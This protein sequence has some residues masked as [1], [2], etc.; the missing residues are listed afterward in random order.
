VPLSGPLDRILALIAMLRTRADAVRDGVYIAVCLLFMAAIP[1]SAIRPIVYE[2]VAPPVP[3][4]IRDRDAALDVDVRTSEGERLPFARVRALAVID[5]RVHAAGEGTTDGEGFVHIEHL[6]RAEHWV[7]ADA[8]GRARGATSVALTQGTRSVVLSLEAEHFLDLDVKDERGG[9]LAGV[10]IEVTGRDPL[11]VGARTDLDGRARVG[12]LT[13]GPYVATARLPGLEEVTQRGLLEGSTAHFVLRRLGVIIARVRDGGQPVPGA[14]VQ[15]SGAT[16]WPPRAADT[17]ATGQLRIASLAAGTYALRANR[18][19]RVSAIE[20]DVTVNGGDERE[21]ELN[22]EP[23]MHVATRVIEGDQEG[24]SD[25]IPIAG[26]RV[27]LVEGGLS[28]FPIE[29]VTD[30]DGQ[31]RL[32]PISRGSAALSARA[33]GYVARGGIPVPEAPSG[34]VVVA[35]PRA[36]TVLGRVVDTRGFPVDG[37]TIVLF[38]TDFQGAPID[39]DPRRTS[40]R[41]AHFSATLAG[42]RPLV[43]AGELGVMPGPVPPIPRATDPVPGVASLAG[44]DPSAKP[45]EPWVTRADGTYRATPATPGRIRALVRHPQYVEVTSDVVTLP[46]GGEA[47]IDV[48]MHAGG[49]LEGHV[50]DARGHAIDGARVTVSAVRGGLERV[51]RTMADGSFAFASLPEAIG[52]TV[53]RDDNPGSPSVSL[54]LTIPDG[55]KR[56]I[57]VTMPDPRPALRVRVNDDR[58]YAL[59]A[60]QLSASSVDPDAPLRS[61]AYTDARGEASIPGARGV[62]IRLEARAPERAP[63]IVSIDADAVEPVIVSLGRAEGATGEVRSSRGDRLPDAEIVLY[64]EMGARR[65]RTDNDGL[66]TLGELSPGAARLVVRAA[67]YAPT[68]RAV[69]IAKSGGNRPTA[70]ARVEL[71]AEGSVNGTVVDAQNRPVQ[72]A[73][74]ARDQVP[75]YLAVGTTPRG[76][77]VSD[78][79]GRFRLGELEEGAVTLEAFAPDVGRVRLEGVRIVAGRTTTGIVLAFPRDSEKRD[80]SVSNPDTAGVAV[81]LG[82]DDDGA[83]VLAAV[84]EGSAAER[85]GLAPG[86]M[87]LEVDGAPVHTMPEARSKMQGPA[88][89]DVIVKLRRGEAPL[90]LRVPREPVRR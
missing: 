74:I 80:T 73:R 37:A 18:G 68:E 49:S 61:T 42:P 54:P 87:L 4:T 82:T 67:G 33:E 32:G 23:G 1:G 89:L 90:T 12:R 13:R 26:A 88:N 77:A 57:T 60:V 43:P 78:A 17:D 76:M 65:T 10:E 19:D 50:V 6:P 34:P 46:S 59:D 62:A 53:T 22:L 72:G 69:S 70:L 39:D 56:E 58:G 3:E 8:P 64:T 15:I 55:Q 16:L 40:F 84:A 79:Q 52:L 45:P 27:T 85:A 7:L 20:F 66:F 47:H 35:L 29:G 31:A 71:K 9:G 30:R 25:A 86:D 38:G 51:T 11:P 41:D 5:G 2:R 14:R 21:V 81:T 44:S 28:P 48:V 83:I 36:G 24:A 75:T 63:T